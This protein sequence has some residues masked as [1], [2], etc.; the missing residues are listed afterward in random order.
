VSK[1]VARPRNAYNVGAKTTALVLADNWWITKDDSK[2]KIKADSFQ[3]VRTTLVY[4]QSEALD[5]ADEPI[6]DAI[7]GESIELDRLYDGLQSG[8]WAIVS[9]ER[10]DIPG[11]SGVRASELVMLSGVIQDVQKIMVGGVKTD[12]PGDKVHTTLVLAAPL[13]Y[14]Y[15][16][17]SVTIAGNVVKATH[18]ETRAEVLG[19]GD[20]STPFQAFTLR[21]PPL[22][23]VSAPTASGQESTLVVRVNGVEWHEVESIVGL[24]PTD[25]V[26]VTRTAD[27][28]KTTIIF[29]DGVRGARLPTGVEN[30]RAAYR[31]GIGRLGNVKAEQISLL[32]TRPLGVKSVVNP[33]RASGGADKETRDQARQNATLATTALDRLV[34]VQDY[35]DFARMFAGVAKASAARLSDGQRM[36]V[37]VTIAGVDDAPIDPGSDVLHNL[38]QALRR[39]GDPYVP[40]AVATRQLLA[41]VISASVRLHPDY[42]WELVEPQIRA[43]LLDTF[44]FAR[45]ELAQPV[46]LSE[47]ISVIQAVAGVVYVDIDFFGSVSENVMA[48]E[49]SALAQQ[50]SPEPAVRARPAQP[51]RAT[52]LDMQAERIRPAQLAYLTPAVPDT[53]ILKELPL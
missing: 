49:L 7:R 27:D 42:L 33:L 14:Q 28:G 29:G 21:Q 24:Q 50:T 48:E 4:A 45:R 8:R 13:A 37:H 36:V 39:Y 52:S 17:D 51:T 12:L 10:S 9:G 35:A 16:R 43:A 31:N 11:T 38:A 32:A 53:L 1:A 18:G 34:S 25:R 6:D 23:Y 2:N 19:A 20:A 26:F 46:Y 22:T 30:V 44:S 15:K 3:I 47:A 5:L 40:I 41:L